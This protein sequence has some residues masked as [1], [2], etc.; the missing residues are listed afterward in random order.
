MEQRSISVCVHTN[1][2]IHDLLK[3]CVWCSSLTLFGLCNLFSTSGCVV[4][5]LLGTSNETDYQ[6]SSLQVAHCSCFLFSSGSWELSAWF[7]SL[8]KTS[9]KC[10]SQTE[11]EETGLQCLQSTDGEGRERGGQNQIQGVQRDISEVLGEPWE[12]DFYHQIQVRSLIWQFY[13]SCIDLCVVK[14]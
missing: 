14:C 6:R 5:L 8:L 11:R 3:Y 4:K 1:I 12:D 9:L 2:S 7:F 13:F 10:P